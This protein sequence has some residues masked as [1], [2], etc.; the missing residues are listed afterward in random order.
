MDR[1]T[2]WL[3]SAE[4]WLDARGKAAWIVAMVLG[5]VFF[6]PIGL[7]ILLYMIW[8]KRMSYRNGDWHARWRHRHGAF[9]PTGNSAFDEYRA[10]T[11]KRLEDEQTAFQSFLDRLRRAKDRAEFEQF[12]EDRRRG[13][14]TGEAPA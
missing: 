5:F 10:E 9:A 6:W 1:I 3:R 11:L 12:M 2:H 14:D 7:A 13:A 4:S 8:S